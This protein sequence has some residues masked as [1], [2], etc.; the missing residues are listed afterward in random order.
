[1]Q[2]VNSR[3]LAV[4]KHLNA[5]GLLNCLRLET[6][7]VELVPTP[8]L[9]DREKEVGECQSQLFVYFYSANEQEV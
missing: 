5:K 8:F 4:F 7:D 9:L 6:R 3:P 1:M 2:I